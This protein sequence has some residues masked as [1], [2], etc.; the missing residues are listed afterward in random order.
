MST[1]KKPI[2]KN[3][4][5][6][7][8]ELQNKLQER[9]MGCLC[10]ECK[11][12][13]NSRQEA[14]LCHGCNKWQHRKCNSGVPREIYR[15]AVKSGEDILWKCKPCSISAVPRPN[16]ESTRN[17]GNYNYE[18]ILKMVGMKTLEHTCRRIEQSLLIFF[19]CFK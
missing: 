9:K 3:L 13:V 18:S 15:D 7:S 2:S 10:T 4:V 17:E 11:K 5:F 8:F 1:C 6:R 16:F 12:F 14:L 19:K